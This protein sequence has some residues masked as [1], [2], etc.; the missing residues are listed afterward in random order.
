MENPINGNPVRTRERNERASERLMCTDY[1]L[2]TGESC[3][4]DSIRFPRTFIETRQRAAQ[5]SAQRINKRKNRGTGV[6]GGLSPADTRVLISVTPRF[7]GTGNRE[8]GAGAFET[9][10]EQNAHG[11]YAFRT[12]PFVI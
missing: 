12:A 4:R 3:N 10:R 9:R 8:P 7:P 1:R 2:L 6:R 5:R 11:R